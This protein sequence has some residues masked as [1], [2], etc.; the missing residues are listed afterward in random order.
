M[1]RPTNGITW[2]RSR[3]FAHTRERSQ[4]EAKLSI[5]VLCNTPTSL[6]LNQAATPFKDEVA[7]PAGEAPTEDLPTVQPQGEGDDNNKGDDGA[8]MVAAILAEMMAAAAV[9]TV[10]TTALPCG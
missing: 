4:Q 10:V 5:D 6:V 3:S 7:H 8:A 9:D 2:K 1:A